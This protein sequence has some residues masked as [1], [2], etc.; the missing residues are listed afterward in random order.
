MSRFG[1]EGGYDLAHD[2]VKEKKG[3]SKRGDKFM[4]RGSKGASWPKQL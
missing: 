4:E 3:K 2:R 1:P